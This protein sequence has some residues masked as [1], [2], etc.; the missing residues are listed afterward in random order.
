MQEPNLFENQQERSVQNLFDSKFVKPFLVIAVLI[1]SLAIFNNRVPN[2][3]QQT[4]DSDWKSD[5]LIQKTRIDFLQERLFKN[6]DQI[7]SLILQNF[8]MNTKIDKISKENDK[9]LT[10]IRQYNLR[11]IEDWLR[12]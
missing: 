12:N 3:G 6:D 9:L 4:I 2:F 5:V 8:E 7:Q 1:F 10:Y 11:L